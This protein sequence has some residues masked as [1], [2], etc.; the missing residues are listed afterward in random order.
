MKTDNNKKLKLYKLIPILITLTG[1]VLMTFMIIEEDE[2]GAIP[3]L[4]IVIGTGWYLV[5]RSGIKSQ[6]A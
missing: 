2:P 1:I 6:R 5:I 3:L 4:L